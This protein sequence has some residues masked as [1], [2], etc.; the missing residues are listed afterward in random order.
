MTCPRTHN[1]S[2]AKPGREAG[3][4]PLRP[5]PGWE[6]QTDTRCSRASRAA[7]QP[8]RSFPIRAHSIQAPRWARL[9]TD[10]GR[11]QELSGAAAAMLSSSDNR[12]WVII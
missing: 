8:A 7:W 2:V 9:L 5:C 11:G 10:V 1:Q 6:G 12:A 4:L 3:V